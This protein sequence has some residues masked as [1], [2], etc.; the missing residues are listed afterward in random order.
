M[1]TTDDLIKQILASSNTSKWSGEGYGS[2]E[3]NAA[4]MAKILNSI[5]ITDINQFGKITSKVDA[6]VRPDGRGG[7][8]D[9][10]GNPV[11]PKLVREESISGEGGDYSYF[12]A[13][14]GTREAFGNKVTGQE[15][16]NTY[17]ERQTGDFFGGTYQGKGN[18]GYGVKFDAQGNPIFYTQGASSSDMKDIAPLL[19][20]AS[21]IPG[22]APFAQGLNAAIAAKQGNVLGALAGAAGLGGYSDIANAAKFANA[23]KSGDPLAIAMSGAG[24]TGAGDMKLGDYS[25]SD[26]GK[27]VG[28]AKALQSGDPTALLRYLSSTGKDSTASSLGP[29][30]KEEFESGLIPGYFLPGG[31]G[32][33]G[34]EVT[35]P[36][37]PT[38]E[39]DPSTVDWE[40]L[41]K[42]GMSPED[43]A[44]RDALMKMGGQEM[45]I[46]P[47]MWKEYNDN[48]IDIVNNKG[49]YTSQWQTVGGDRIMIQDDGTAIATNEN[50]DPYSLDADQVTDMINKGLLN[51]DESGY[52]AATGGSKGGGA[53]PTTKTATT[54]T[55][56]NPLSSLAGL[57]QQQGPILPSQDPFAH[58]KLMKELFGT[59]VDLTPTDSSDNTTGDNA[60]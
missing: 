20:I 28:A 56:Q 49:G 18:T 23:V 3:K 27:T 25:L 42:E 50:G 22:V 10:K 31:E 55:T 24:M 13:P 8:V 58:I 51:T 40:A 60:E 14:V 44:K 11:D 41:A 26:I 6:Q 35:N 33:M 21:F 43:I 5:G 54:P 57:Q 4:D 29:G 15:V 17:S 39:F 30:T 36:L 48:L 53:K 2:A 37:G 12:V 59:D 16:P 9:D 34:K 38:E 46:D 19:T 47:N 45:Q 32:Y 1:S 52:T 7:Y